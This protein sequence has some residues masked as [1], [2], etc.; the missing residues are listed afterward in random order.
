MKNVHNEVEQFFYE[1]IFLV[2]WNLYVYTNSRSTVCILS[3]LIRWY[4]KGEV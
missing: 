1:F 4:C 3:N 2:L